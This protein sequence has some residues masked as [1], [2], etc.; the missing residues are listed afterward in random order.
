MKQINIY[1][2]FQD[3]HKYFVLKLPWLRFVLKFQIMLKKDVGFL[4]L[5]KEVIHFF[6]MRN[7]ILK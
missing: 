5:S 6:K 4:C 2:F 7:T 1:T 3:Q